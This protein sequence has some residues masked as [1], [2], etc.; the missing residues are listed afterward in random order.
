MTVIVILTS[1]K[2]N[3]YDYLRR[4][5]K[6]NEAVVSFYGTTAALTSRE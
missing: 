1:N 4:T 6:D 3:E 2:I 5:G